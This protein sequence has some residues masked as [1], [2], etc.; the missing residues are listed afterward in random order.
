MLHSLFV[1]PIENDIA[2]ASR[3]YVLLPDNMPLIPIHALRKNSI[4][5][6]YLT[7]RLLVSYLPAAEALGFKAALPS[8]VR[9]VVALGHP[10]TSDWDVEYELR[11]IRAFYKETR[12]YFSQ[13]ATLGTLRKERADL[14]HLAVELRWDAHSPGNSTMILQDSKSPAVVRNISLEEIL[15]LPAYPAVVVSNLAKGYATIHPAE[16]YL[17]LANGTR[18]VIMDGYPPLRKTKK[19]FGEIFYTALLGGMPVS[20]AYH[21][22]QLEMIRNPDYAPMRTWGAFFM[23]GR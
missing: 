23:W 20:E 14:L 21:Q 2:G 19:Y 9:E 6:G 7:E 12:L 22:V 17:F 16:P 1:R 11:D 18:T 13:Q 5:A 4:Q 3:L 15:G 8:A 10:G